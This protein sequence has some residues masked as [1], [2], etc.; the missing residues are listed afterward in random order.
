[1]EEDAKTQQLLQSIMRRK[2]NS[3][4]AIAFD[5]ASSDDDS[6]CRIAIAWIS[7]S[8]AHSMSCLVKPP[9][10]D[11]SCSRKVTASMVAHSADF[12][13][14]WDRRILPLLKGDVLALYDASQ[15]LHALK[16]SYE[17]SGR[18]F[19]LPE[20]YIRDLRFLAI[21]YMPGLG[22]DSF[23]SIIHRLRLRA[24]LDDAARRATA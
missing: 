9:T 3:A 10:D 12:A 14:V 16:A 6:I 24:D 15:T 17:T 21:T 23:I 4:I 5:K 2:N 11:F 19:M 22:N 8:K 18:V 1:M 7:E 20:L 13:T